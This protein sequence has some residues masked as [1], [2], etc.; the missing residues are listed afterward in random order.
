M[1]RSNSYPVLPELTYSV[2]EDGYV[3]GI[4]S[5]KMNLAAEMFEARKRALKLHNSVD[6]YWKGVED[7]IDTPFE[8][9]KRDFLELFKANPYLFLKSLKNSESCRREIVKL[10]LSEGL[11]NEYYEHTRRGKRFL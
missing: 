11:I 5:A 3:L 2:L 1:I 9:L 8:F 6:I 10:L 7:S 4:I